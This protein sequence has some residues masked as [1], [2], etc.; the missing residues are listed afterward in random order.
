[1]TLGFPTVLIPALQ[2]KENATRINNNDFT[3]NA[4]QVSW[5]SSINLICVPLGCVFSGTFTSILGR[6]KAMQLVCLPILAAWVIFYYS[7]NVYHLYVALCLSGFAGKRAT[8]AL[9]VQFIKNSIYVVHS[10]F[11]SL[12]CREV[13]QVL[14]LSCRRNARSAGADLRRRNLHAKAPRNSFCF[15]E[16]LRYSR[17]VFAI[18]DGTLLRVAFHQLDIDSCSNS[19]NSVLVL[20]SG[21]ATLASDEKPRRRCKEISDV[22]AWVASKLWR[23]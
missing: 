2:E 9:L 18:S 23:R 20:R 16:L 11:A 14:F 8:R 4:A 22:V 19:S 15:W 7:T 10:T 21:V 12:N 6:K 1:M 3:I 13:Q 17:S 5:T